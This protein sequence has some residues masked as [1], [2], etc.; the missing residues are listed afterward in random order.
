LTTDRSN[1][2][3]LRSPRSVGQIVE[4]AVSVYGRYP[5]LFAVLA[6][7]VVAPYDLVVLAV[8]G[9]APLGRQ[10]ATVSTALSLTLLDFALIGP[11]VSALD[12]HA[13]V[14]IG[15]GR[16][17]RLLNVAWR[18]LRV[19]PVV[20]AAQIVAGIGIGVGFFALL[21]PGVIL[22]IRWAVVAQVAALEHT[23]WLGALRRSGELT[24]GNYLHVLG[25]IAVTAVVGLAL[26]EAGA[27]VVQTST[28]APQ[29]LLGIVLD[30]A[31]RT[32]AALSAAI[33]FFDLVARQR[34]PRASVG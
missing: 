5:L 8:T 6:L 24:R 26:R 25:I 2:I 22:L 12:I 4:A 18:G 13:L 29:V 14:A 34:Q 7:A 15:E 11:L 20:A 27:A 1:S 9:S 32:F 23:D 17:P 10:G 30:T 19:L 21:V 33:L 31:A 16:R 3:D 28:A